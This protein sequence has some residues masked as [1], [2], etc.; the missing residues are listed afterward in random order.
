MKHLFA[1]FAHPDDEAFGPAG[2]LLMEADAGTKLHL[3]LLTAG[4]NGINPGHDD[5]AKVRKAEWRKSGKLL[6]ATTQT[7]FGYIDGDLSNT[8]MQE[9]TR[10]LKKH[11]TSTAK[12]ADEIELMSFEFSGI[13]GHIDHIVAARASAQAFC[14]LKAADS[15]LT[16]LR[17]FCLPHGLRPQRDTSWIYAEA[18]CDES[19]IDEVIDARHLRRR[20]EAVM[21][22]HASQA[23]DATYIKKLLGEELGMNWFS[24]ID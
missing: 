4:E 1:I 8:T 19:S 12:D 24:I 20:I 14:R 5:L 21:D 22:A 10:R 15:R 17:L 16:R 11:I 9:I 13:S 6:G 23:N 2:T 3:V 18:G 7:F